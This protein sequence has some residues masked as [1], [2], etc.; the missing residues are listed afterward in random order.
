MAGT[1]KF[2]PSAAVPDLYKNKTVVLCNLIDNN[3]IHRKVAIKLFTS[4]GMKIVEM[5]AQ[6]HDFHAAFISHM[7]HAISYALANSVYESRSPTRD[8]IFSSRRI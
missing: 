4:I 3:E 7:P 6:E 5:T 1:E 8:H 2:G